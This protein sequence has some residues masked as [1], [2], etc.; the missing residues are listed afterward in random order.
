MG[1]EYFIDER[2]DRLCDGKVAILLDADNGVTRGSFRKKKYSD[3]IFQ[4]RAA[5]VKTDLENR[6]VQQLGYYLKAFTEK[7]L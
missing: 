5:C 6:L 1:S 7:V 2:H 4:R 3:P